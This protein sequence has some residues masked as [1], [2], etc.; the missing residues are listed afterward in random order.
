MRDEDRIRILHMIEAT[1]AVAQFVEG[2]SREDLDRDRMLLFAV[3]H[4]P[5]D[6]GGR[7]TSLGSAHIDA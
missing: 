5:G 4:V 1:E 7:L 3:V 6:P 2:R